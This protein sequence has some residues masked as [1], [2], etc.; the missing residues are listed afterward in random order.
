MSF[1]VTRDERQR[2]IVIARGGISA[3]LIASSYRM[4][5]NTPAFIHTV[6]LRYPRFIHSELMTHRAFSRN[7]ASSRAIPV[8]KMITQVRND[9]A[10]PIH[11]GA[12]QPGMQ[13]HQ[14]LDGDTRLGAIAEWKRAARSAAD[15]AEE[16][17]VLGTHKQIANRILEPFQFMNTIVTATEW[18]NFFDLR[19]HPDAQP[20][21]QELA[22]AIHAL[23]TFACEEPGASVHRVSGDSF[24]WHDVDR[25]HLPYVEQSERMSYQLPVLLAIS[26]A[27]C[28]RVSYL[29]HDGEKPNVWNDIQLFLRL[30][31][32]EPLHAS[33]IEHQG[34]PTKN[35]HERSANF[36]GWQ[37]FRPAFGLHLEPWR[38]FVEVHRSTKE[39][40]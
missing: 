21:F 16:L 25:W 3:T 30:V 18:S 37:Q 29:T 8:A 17:N 31:G 36:L 39:A 32:S 15:Y 2:P 27:R 22:Y 9:P 12:N 35:P 23:L 6:Q 1:D 34:C 14:E 33:P 20:E 19:A 11:W 4:G 10:M 24:N 13:A 7:A 28:A 40:A 38:T 5:F 26:A